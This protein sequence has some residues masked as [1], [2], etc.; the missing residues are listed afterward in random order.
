MHKVDRNLNSDFL[1]FFDR[2]KLFRFNKID[3][4]VGK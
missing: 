1:N 3:Y 2:G 4:V